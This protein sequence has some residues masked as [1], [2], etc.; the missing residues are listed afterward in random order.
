[1][2]NKFKIYY[3]E[4]HPDPE[5]AGKVFDPQGSYTMVVMNPDGIFYLYY[6]EYFRPTFKKLSTILPKY[7]VVWSG[8]RE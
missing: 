4:D 5:K 6:T 1:M 7:E 3:P 8:D 2:R